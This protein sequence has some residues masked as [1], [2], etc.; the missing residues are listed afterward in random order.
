MKTVFSKI[1]GIVLLSIL[2]AGCSSVEMFKEKTEFAPYK[3]YT[4]FAILNKE[5][6]QRG[7][8][9][10]FLDAMVLDGLER[11]LQG[12]GMV[13]DPNE[14]EIILR[15]TSNEDPR[16][17][18]IVNNMMPMWGY[19]VWDPWMFDP[20]FM[21]RPPV[22]TKNYELMQLI[23]DF[24][25]P[26]NDKMLMRLTAVSEVSSPKDKQKKVR[27]SVEK[28]VDTYFDHMKNR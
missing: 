23:V 1:I 27:K 13:Y 15:Y 25:D 7:F 18:E 20:R 10:A 11:L 24:V 2:L 12:Q 8:R 17:K 4:T 9:D 14:P 5:F 28:V 22:S 16:Q 6:D 3:E 19:R 21:N 26:K